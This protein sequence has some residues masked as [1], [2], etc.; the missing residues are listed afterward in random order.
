MLLALTLAASLANCRV[1]NAHYVLRTDPGTTATFHALKPRPQTIGM[2]DWPS[3]LALSIHLRRT[4]RTYWFLPEPDGTARLQHFAST[5]DITVPGWKPGGP[6]PLREIDYI[7]TDATYRVI[8]DVPHLG[9]IAPAHMLF[10]DLGQALWYRT[11]PDRRDGAPK[12]F[13]DLVSCKHP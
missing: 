5:P 7:A 3:H 12:Q 4:N 6:R 2:N 10:A 9:E 11:P 1:E 8:D 13:F